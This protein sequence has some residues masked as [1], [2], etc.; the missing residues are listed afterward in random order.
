MNRQ[1]ILRPTGCDLKRLPLGTREAFFLSQLDGQLTLE[2][3]S[4]IAGLEIEETLRVAELL[5]SLGAVSTIE[6][7]DSKRWSVASRASRTPSVTEDP[8]RRSGSPDP[9]A[10]LESDRPPSGVAAQASP[11]A[12]QDASKGPNRRP[13]PAAA[14]RH[15]TPRPERRRS[16]K[17]IAQQPAVRP[18]TSDVAACDLDDATLAKIASLD[19]KLEK[20]TY[21]ELLEIERDADKKEIKRAYFRLASVFHPDRYFGKRLGQAALAIGRIFHRLTEANDTLTNG[22]L[23][24]MYDARLPKAP[25]TRRDTAATRR[26]SRALKAVSQKLQAIAAPPPVDEGA[27]NLGHPPSSE[28]LERPG[29]LRAAVL[30]LQTQANVDRLVKAAEAAVAAQDIAGAANNYRLA[31]SHRED[32]LVRS[33]YEAVNA[34]A[35]TLRFDKN[36]VPARAAERDQRWADASIFLVRAYEARPDC[37]VASRA[38]NALRRGGGDLARA[39][40]LGEHSV[41]LDPNNVGYRIVLSE[42]YLA[43]NQLDLAE[44]AYVEA[45][46]LAPKDARLKELSAA[47][48]QRAKS[49]SRR[50]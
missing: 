32:P 11:S 36:I 42:V 17:S 5:A 27:V 28:A 38:A 23:R 12:T 15:P 13:A 2:E 4:E 9:R 24:A 20:L 8:R 33:K 6:R 30:E 18:G 29:R 31:L 48:T 37:D 22:E 14:T 41:K 49:S 46:A 25:P 39:V 21:Y 3:I 34:H 43:A 40:Q 10:E 7:T 16:R 50:P 45:T 19:A 47:I 26:A 35:S 44:A 1:T